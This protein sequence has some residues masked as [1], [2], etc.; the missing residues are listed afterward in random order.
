M[1]PAKTW[2]LEAWDPDSMPV[3][4]TILIIGKRHTGKTVLTR[5]L[6]HA[7]RKK[8]DVCMGMNPLEGGNHNLSYFCPKAF[9]FDT[10]NDEKLR[11][12]LAWQ[13]C[14]MKNGKA[15]KIGFVM[16]DCASET[17]MSGGGKKGKKAMASADIGKLFKLGRHLRLFYINAMQDVK[18]APPDIRGNVDLLFAF[19]TNSGAER[20][21]LHQEFFGM[22]STFK[23]FNQVFD[24]GAQG[25]DCIVLDT[26]KAATDPDHCIMF[27]RAPLIK[28]P[29]RVG[30]EIFYKLS[31]YFF[32]D[33][34]DYSMDPSRILGLSSQTDFTVRKK[35][36]RDKEDEEE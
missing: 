9:V 20:Q 35:A 14:A 31:D 13:T 22:F 18:N 6:M 26:R 21:K 16:D 12:L 30:R 19:N 15:H 11:H 34:N 32:E 17:T 4:A 25:Y 8:L 5:A 7:M 3:D 2:V 28:E 24:A 27:Y 29:F 10:F 33:K 36:H 1:N 23:N